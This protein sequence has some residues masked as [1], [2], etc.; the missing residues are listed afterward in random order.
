MEDFAP[1][2]RS[3]MTMVSNVST[4]VSFLLSSLNWSNV[5]FVLPI[6]VRVPH[7]LLFMV[8]DFVLTICFQ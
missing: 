1:F 2:I 5:S 6:Y 7:N 8:S 3:S 4:S